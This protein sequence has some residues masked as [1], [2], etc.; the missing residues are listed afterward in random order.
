MAQ[1]NDDKGTTLHTQTF[2]YQQTLLSKAKNTY[3]ISYGTRHKLHTF[4]REP[5]A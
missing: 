4:S 5:A 3:Y 2:H 1:R